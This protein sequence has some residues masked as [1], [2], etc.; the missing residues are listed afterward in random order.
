MPLVNGPT[1]QPSF[2]DFADKTN[3]KGEALA[4][5]LN[6]AQARVDAGID[7]LPPY[8][9]EDHKFGLMSEETEEK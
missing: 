6:E 8:E 2:E 5:Q 1:R 7:P 3:E 9:E 4:R